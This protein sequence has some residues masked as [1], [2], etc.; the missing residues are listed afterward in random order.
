[1]T[2]SSSG[3]PYSTIATGL[4]STTQIDAGLTNG[5]TYYYVVTAENVYGESGFSNEAAV[6]PSAPAVPD[7]PSAVTASAGKKKVTIRWDSVAGANS[8]NVKSS[9]ADGGPYTAV[10][11]G[12]SGTRYNHTGLDSGTTYYYVV[13]AENADGESANSAQASAT[14]K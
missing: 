10:A 6:T 12:L 4:A 14:A 8:Y 11:S 1:V 9:L 7:A 13:S 3:G 5:D 2:G